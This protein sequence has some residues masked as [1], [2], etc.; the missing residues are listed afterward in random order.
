MNDRG[1]GGRGQG[2]GGDSLPQLLLDA[3]DREKRIRDVEALPQLLL[4]A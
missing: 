2:C 3:N 4:W 1:A